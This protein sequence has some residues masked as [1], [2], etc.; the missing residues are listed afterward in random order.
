[1]LRNKD[2][3]VGHWSL[4]SREWR[5]VCMVVIMSISYK[6]LLKRKFSVI[7]VC[8]NLLCLGWCDHVMA[9]VFMYFV[10]HFLAKQLSYCVK[11]GL[12]A[13]MRNFL[14]VS[15]GNK[16]DLDHQSC[17][18]PKDQIG[19]WKKKSRMGLVDLFG[20][21]RKVGACLGKN[22]FLFLNFENCF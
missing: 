8:G 18:H 1:M 12:L 4:A 10:G 3:L 14:E 21:E 9:T 20:N 15:C 2:E 11:T 6:N 16:W 22:S 13:S 5:H 7:W 17:L 19:L